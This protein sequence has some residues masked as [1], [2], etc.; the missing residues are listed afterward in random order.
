M[1]LSKIKPNC[2]TYNFYFNVIASCSL[3]F[4]RFFAMRKRQLIKLMIQ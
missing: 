4:R 2:L 1:V 3:V